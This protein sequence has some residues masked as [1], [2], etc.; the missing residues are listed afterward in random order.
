MIPDRRDIT[1]LLAFFN[2]IKFIKKIIL[3]I[4]LVFFFRKNK[5][6]AIFILFSLSKTRTKKKDL[7][8]ISK[9]ISKKLL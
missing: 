1:N 2:Y 6:S 7:K 9:K 4:Y 8:N 5:G 3:T